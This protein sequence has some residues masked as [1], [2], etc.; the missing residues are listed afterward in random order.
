MLLLFLLIFSNST[1][2]Y[3]ITYGN[4]SSTYIQQ[5]VS[6]KMQLLTKQNSV[7][8]D[9]R[10]VVLS[11]AS[12][13]ISSMWDKILANSNL[14]VSTEVLKTYRDSIKN[15]VDRFNASY[16]DATGQDFHSTSINI[17]YD[18]DS[19]S[20]EES[21]KQYPSKVFDKTK[22]I[23]KETCTAI[24]DDIVK[25]CD[26]K[27]DSDKQTIYK[28]YNLEIKSVYNLLERAGQEQLSVANLMSE[29]YEGN[30]KESINVKDLTSIMT[31]DKYKEIMEYARDLIEKSIL[32]ST[33][34]GLED[35]NNNY[36][37]FT[38]VIDGN[39]RRVNLAYLS[40]MAISSTYIPFISKAGDEKNLNSVKAI[41]GD[42]D[43]AQAIIK[44]YSDTVGRVKPLY[45]NNVDKKG[46]L[47]GSASRITVEEFMKD[48]EDDSSGALV[49][50]TGQFK[51]SED[52]DT[53]SFFNNSDKQEDVNTGEEIASGTVTSNAENKSQEANGNESD[54]DNS[55]L[56][57]TLEDDEGNELPLTN[58]MTETERRTDPLVIYGDFSKKAATTKVV[59]WNIQ[60]DYKSDSLSEEYDKRW[61]YINGW[62]D[63]VLDDGTIVL[64]AAA[65]PSY[66]KDNIVYNCNTAAFMNSYP[67]PDVTT[68]SMTMT[69][70]DKDKYIISQEVEGNID[71]Q[72][73]KGQCFTGDYLDLYGYS[74]VG[75]TLESEINAFCYKTTSLN[76]AFKCLP[77]E[78]DMFSNTE[79]RVQTM[80]LKYQGVDDSNFISRVISSPGANIR[81]DD[82]L[83]LVPESPKYQS[84]TE[85]A[86][87]IFP[88]TQDTS[89]SILDVIAKRYFDDMTT[90]QDGEVVVENG[91]MDIDWITGV[92]KSG[93][94][95]ITNKAALVKNV[96]KSYTELRQV[97]SIVVTLGQFVEKILN[98]LGDVD[99]V[100]GLKNAYQDSGWG[101][102]LN[103]VRDFAPFIII[104]II[105]YFITCFIRNRVNIIAAFSYIALSVLLAYASIMII[106]VYIPILLNGT[107]STCTNEVSYKSLYM[108]A[109]KYLNPYESREKQGVKSSSMTL[110]RFQEDDLVNLANRFNT[111]ENNLKSGAVID[112]DTSAGTYVEGDLI[113]I[114]VDK[115]LSSLAITG[116]YE[117]TMAGSLYTLK[118]TKRIS[119]SIDY[120]NP[121][122]L[123]TDAFI[124]KLNLTSKLFDLSPTQLNYGNSLTKDSFL[125][126]SYVC[127]DL[128]LNRDDFSVFDNPDKYVNITSDQ[129]REI[130]GSS[131]NIDWLGI[132]SVV[133]G[134][135]FNRNF[136]SIKDTLWFKSMVRN[137]FY[138]E[139]GSIKNEDKM[140]NLITHV[141][142]TT[143][144]FVLDNLN[145]MPY[146]SDENMIKVIALYATIDFDVCASDYL[147]VIYPQALNYEELG[148]SDVLLP[149]I[150]K[151]YDRYS[152]QDR[153]II[154]YIEYDYSWWGL[155]L[156]GMVIVL[157]W[158]IVTAMKIAI[159]ILY[160]VLV[161]SMLA[162]F[163]LRN[164]K[165]VGAIIS[166]FM[167]IAGGIMAAYLIFCYITSACYKFNDSAKCLIILLVV[168]ILVSIIIFSVLMTF[169]SKLGDFSEI[170]VTSTLSD[171]GRK[172]SKLPGLKKLSASIAKAFNRVRRTKDGDMTDDEY[173]NSRKGDPLN[174]FRYSD[175][176][177]D[178]SIFNEVIQQRHNWKSDQPEKEKKK[179]TYKRSKNS[180]K[181]TNM[182]RTDHD[183]D[184]EN[185]DNFKL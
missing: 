90:S 32:S 125:V 84:T 60:K 143:Q 127:S 158:L 117:N 74:K 102:V 4:T 137:G 171:I 86:G 43:K 62:G 130:F 115:F 147:N 87:V 164:N 152:A 61:L 58:N 13:L 183:P 95:G 97:S 165:N 25:E 128:F 16:K 180:E 94:D 162:R 114:D 96:R 69:E 136:D 166:G 27:G 56:G 184:S 75:P 131:D 71:K 11:E 111:T 6:R 106:P 182:Y 107:I 19:Y 163:S 8:T 135:L 109:E 5:V 63:V 46:N 154:E 185:F 123:V 3:A 139:D 73:K 98:V 140:A 174:S 44:A 145:Q 12:I 167:Q 48:I 66:L 112:L 55:K 149:V 29:K 161:V 148:I 15:N 93:Y 82:E 45:K 42:N 64:P 10:G 67:K 33:D 20:D 21:S 47:T 144:Q 134:D 172:F 151:D 173:Y 169:A 77:M 120:Y 14:N 68:N 91:R 146:L 28:S 24:L 38:S 30:L 50:Y 79:E 133:A 88:V 54:V 121:Y 160:A 83:F 157:G 170:K 181:D 22:E 168:Y 18:I 179:F 175:D 119:N 150:T 108:R 72:L 89:Q 155:I 65:N 176:I 70:R 37:K 59:L 113:K 17:D 92:F 41:V 80:V 40:C 142:N 2:C 85:T 153:N 126:N 116:T 39:R 23:A 26:G 110:Y 34:I 129:V 35:G 53:W 177:Y 78:L 105:I 81:L 7:Y 9:D 122:Y 101:R 138:N 103:Y 156:F 49:T 100:I 104:A 1:T 99:G 51:K 118:S 132:K 52:V 124:D 159:P 141:N 178:S 36:N 76:I 31:N 57:V